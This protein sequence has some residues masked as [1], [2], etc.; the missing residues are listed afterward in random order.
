MIVS[1]SFDA[2]VRQVANSLGASDV[3]ATRWEERNGVLTGSL[4]GENI[5]GPQKALRFRQWLAGESPF[6]YAYGDSEGD[7]EL[8]LLA[9]RPEW[10]SSQR[11]SAAPDSD[12]EG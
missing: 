11:V 1:A 12:G 10:V 8:L 3:I 7:R 2:Y 9:H 5:R 6:V 4:L